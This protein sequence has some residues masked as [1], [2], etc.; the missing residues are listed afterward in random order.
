[1]RRSRRWA[2]RRCGPGLTLADVPP[3]GSAVIC[4][5]EG[6][7]VLQERLRALGLREGARIEVVKQAPLADPREY[8]V[9][10]VHL[11]LRHTEAL[12]IRVGGIVE[13]SG[14]RPHGWGWGGR[15][16]GRWG[17][18]RRGGGRRRCGPAG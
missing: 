2:A 15:R 8:R 6:D 12:G 7:E 13:P 14:P 4:E 5:L 3:G 18:G 10:G 9:G 16:W 17:W 1:M 11:S